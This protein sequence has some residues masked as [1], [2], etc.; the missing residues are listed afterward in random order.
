MGNDVDAEVFRKLFWRV[1][2]QLTN[3]KK[4]DVHGDWCWAVFEDNEQKD[5]DF[6]KVIPIK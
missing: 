1:K 3:A 6:G 4:L 2:T 5:G